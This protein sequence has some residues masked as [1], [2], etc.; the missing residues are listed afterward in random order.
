MKI[1]VYVSTNIVGS[2]REEEFEIDDGLSEEKIEEI[3]REAMFEMI[4]WGFE[5]LR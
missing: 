4:E 5:V 3:A 1:K 2:E